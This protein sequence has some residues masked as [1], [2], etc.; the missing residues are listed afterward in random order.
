MN[1][2]EFL[3][4][5]YEHKEIKKPLDIVNDKEWFFVIEEMV[6]D[7][8]KPIALAT[9]YLLGI[10]T[11]KDTEKAKQI[12]K[13][14]FGKF[15]TKELFDAC[16]K[17]GIEVSEV[18]F[19]K[20]TEVKGYHDMLDLSYPWDRSNPDIRALI[21]E[22]ADQK[23]NRYKMMHNV[24]F[25]YGDYGF[26]G[27][28]LKGFMECSGHNSYELYKKDPKFVEGF[29]KRCLITLTHK[30]NLYFPTVVDAYLSVCEFGWD[31]DGYPIKKLDLDVIEQL[32]DKNIVDYS[33]V[34]ALRS[35]G[36]ERDYAKYPKKVLELLAKAFR[37]IGKNQ[38]SI[39][40]EKLLNQLDEKTNK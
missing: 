9:V 10:G 4:A 23:G 35:Q 32:I 3:D 28:F 36:H 40:Y 8:V 31:K 6:E 38:A 5:L 21:M 20:Q 33:I 27:G 30:T 37:L 22:L 25:T 14:G 2:Y 19:N 26:P 15:K 16:K 7:S 11:D 34:A 18:E 13:E 39:G 12:L 24:A 17:Q 1:V 29:Y